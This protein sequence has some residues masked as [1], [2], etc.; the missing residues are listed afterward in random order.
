MNEV[1]PAA[2]AL[3]ALRLVEAYV[4]DE[5]DGARFGAREAMAT[6]GAERVRVTDDRDANLGTVTLA[7]GRVTAKV[8][9]EQAF[10]A[11]VRKNHPGELVETVRDSFRR[12]VLDE[13][14]AKAEAGDP[15]AVG[16]DGEVLPGVEV[17]HGLPYLACRPTDEAR[18]RMR[19]V[20]STSPLRALTSG[21]T[22]V[23]DAA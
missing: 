2:R 7:V 15:T 5:I 23:P 9:D 4:K 1:Q 16:P 13:A 17:V 11:W 3:L 21:I 12:K 18:R 19:E 20:L 22:E 10:L 14:V 6:V 8:T